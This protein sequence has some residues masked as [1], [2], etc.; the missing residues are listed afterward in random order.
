MTPYLVD[1]RQEDHSVHGT[2]S[3]RIFLVANIFPQLFVSAVLAPS[4]NSSRG[5]DGEV[6]KPIYKKG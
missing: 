2:F 3:V 4:T 5:H 1:S 6:E